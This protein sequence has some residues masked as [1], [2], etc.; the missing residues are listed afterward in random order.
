[1]SKKNGMTFP[2]YSELQAKELTSARKELAAFYQ[3]L[4]RLSASLMQVK[5]LSTH[6]LHLEMSQKLGEEIYS[7]MD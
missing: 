2:D 4:E 3:K 7:E 1:M 5:K 6:Q